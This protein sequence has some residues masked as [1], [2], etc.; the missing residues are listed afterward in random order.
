MDVLLWH[1]LQLLRR[2][3]LRQRRHLLVDSVLSREAG[4]TEETAQLVVEQAA[5]W[6]AVR[7]SKHELPGL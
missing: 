3:R 4:P 2:T 7:L 1:Q 6:V 5:T